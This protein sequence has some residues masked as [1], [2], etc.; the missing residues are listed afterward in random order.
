MG[1]ELV[2]TTNAAVQK[3][4]QRILSA[5]SRQKSY[6]DSRRKDLKFAVGDHVFLKVAPMREVLRFGK[7][8]K[9]SPRFVGPFEVLERIGLVAYR[10]ALPPILAAMHNVF[11]VSILRK[12][13]SYPTYIIVHETLPIR[14]DLSYEKKPIGIMARDV[15]RLR[16][17]EIPIVKVLWENNR[18]NEATWE[19]EDDMRRSYTK[20]FGEGST[21]KDES[22]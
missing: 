6:A 10:L 21:F 8:G 20:L 5:Q 4:K 13:T 1:P 19:C 11:H 9:L 7:K 15:R 12:Y 17:R 16:R 22:S 3:I 18:G 14:K 2:Q